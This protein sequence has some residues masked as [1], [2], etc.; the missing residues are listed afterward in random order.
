M[1]KVM[2]ALVSI[3]LLLVLVIVIGLVFLSALMGD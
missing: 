2:F 1:I 3:P